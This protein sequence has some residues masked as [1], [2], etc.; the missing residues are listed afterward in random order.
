MVTN[1]NTVTVSFKQ[2]TYDD[3]LNLKSELQQNKDV[4]IRIK[5]KYRRNTITW[6]DVG[7]Y[8]IELSKLTENTKVSHDAIKSM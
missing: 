2:D 6:D 1:E 3:F 4:M 7:R 5:E 8:L